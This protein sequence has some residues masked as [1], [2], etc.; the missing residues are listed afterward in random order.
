[1]PRRAEGLRDIAWCR[2]TARCHVV[3]RDPA[4]PCR[5]EGPRDATALQISRAILETARRR[6][7]RPRDVPF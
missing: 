5:A 2:E 3:Q 4:K 6:I 1:M 7:E